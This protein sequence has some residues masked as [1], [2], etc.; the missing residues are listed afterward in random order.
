MGRGNM[1]GKSPLKTRAVTPAALGVRAHSGWAALVVVAGTPQRPVVTARRRIVIADPAIPG[2]KQPYHAAEGWPLSKARH[3]LERCARRTK[4]L[5]A[6][7]VRDVLHEAQA[8]GQTLVGCGLLTASGR[9]MPA[10]EHAL[11]SHAMLHTA[12]GEFF[13]RALVEASE[14]CRVRV[15]RIREKELFA[16]A[17]ALLRMHAAGLQRRVTRLGRPLGPPWSQDEKR[18]ALVAWIVLAAAARPKPATVEARG[19]KSA[20]RSASRPGG[21]PVRIPRGEP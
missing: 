5:A 19:R 18:A 3:Y 12:E 15:S 20:A 10:L 8:G 7:G 4:R 17:A 6:R 11:S 1:P 14:A 2:S 21:L 9:P 16:Q 13:R